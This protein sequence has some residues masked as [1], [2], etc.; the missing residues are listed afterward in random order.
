M[1]EHIGLRIW[2]LTFKLIADKL[3]E[4]FTHGIGMNQLQNNSHQY[5]T[6]FL[7][8]GRIEF[9]NLR[10][11]LF[12]DLTVSHRIPLHGMH[13][14]HAIINRQRLSCSVIQRHQ[15]Q[16]TFIR[17]KHR[18]LLVKPTSGTEK[19]YIFRNPLE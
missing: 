18:F 19:K 7:R 12:G 16:H 11:N 6:R 14:M 8:L 10:K 4:F 2:F 15:V 9:G 13:H 17:C 3:E 1:Q 5:R